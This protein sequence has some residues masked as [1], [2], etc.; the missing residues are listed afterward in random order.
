MNKISYNEVYMII[1]S[2]NSC[3]ML[4]TTNLLWINVNSNNMLA[5]EKSDDIRDMEVYSF[6]NCLAT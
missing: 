5:P 1:Y 2:I 6:S 4:C 3:I